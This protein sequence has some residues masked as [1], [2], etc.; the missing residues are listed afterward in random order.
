MGS[1]MADDI[2]EATRATAELSVHLEKATNIKTGNLDF[3]K[4]NQSIKSSGK[5]LEAYGDQLLKLGP[6]GR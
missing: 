2:R 4:L 6:E 5:S 1:G 3:S